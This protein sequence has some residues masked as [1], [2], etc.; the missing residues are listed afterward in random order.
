MPASRRNPAPKRRREAAASLK[1]IRAV[2]RAIEVLEALS[3]SGACSLAELNRTTGIAK[4]TIRRLLLTLERGR[5]VRCSL[6][7]GL[8]RANVLV[9]SQEEL[10]Q[11]PLIAR[12]VEA[13]RPVMEEMATTVVW[14]S[15]LVVR[16]GLQLRIVESNR[17][18]VALSVNRNE[19]G[20]RVDIVSTAAGR[21]YLAFCPDA[22]R[23]EL[24]EAIAGTSGRRTS[25]DIERVIA[26]TRARGW[27][28][29]GPMHTGNTERFPDRHDKLS[30]VAMPIMHRRRVYGCINLLWPRSITERI[31]GLPQ[32][33]RVLGRQVSRIE[34]NLARG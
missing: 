22:E 29:R 24:L 20:D 30:A 9:P 33:A 17:S 21:A 4:S 26:E 13:A 31:G 6:A 28:E 12:L 10:Q 16:D 23:L 11:T 32:M 14:P 5:F 19:I 2:A 18:I 7:D 1:E 25:R 27:A 8:Y 3:R 15:D 34:S